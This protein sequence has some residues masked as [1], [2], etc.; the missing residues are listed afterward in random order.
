MPYVV[1]AVETSVAW[2]TADAAV[3]FEG[4][5][6]TVRPG[7]DTLY[8]TV[9]LKYEPDTKEARAEA[10]AFMRR[11]LSSLS[12]AERFGIQVVMESGGGFPI[13]LGR[14]DVHG[15]QV[16]GKWSADY[17][18]EP[19]TSEAR[20]ALAFYRE[21]LILE[22]V[23][24]P[25]SFLGFFKILNIGLPN[26]KG[27]IDW[28]NVAI[29]NIKDHRAVERIAEL[30]V[31]EPNLGEYLY[32]SGRC[33]VAHAF[34]DPVVNPDDSTDTLRLV[35]DL[36]VARALAEYFIETNLGVKSYS[37][38]LSEHRYELAGFAAILGDGLVARLKSGEALAA[39]ECP[40]FPPLNIRIDE[41]DD[42]TLSN[43]VVTKIG[44]APG[45][46]ILFCASSDAR[47]RLTLAL[48]FANER[49]IFDPERDVRVGDDGSARA[50]EYALVLLRFFRC[51]VLN[52]RT[53]V[54]RADT[55]ERLGR[56]DAYIG[57]N[58]ELKAVVEDVDR[59]IARLTADHAS[60]LQMMQST[61]IER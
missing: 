55:G 12:W 56:T 1:F 10:V 45:T 38:V 17:L 49:L 34:A 7:S 23:S 37:N 25:Y 24:A 50:V 20:L 40:A 44:S 47:L 36:P 13:Q 27:Q 42:T 22:H 61:E 58:I 43:L 53:E 28:T 3:L 2:T 35:R 18:P 39:T 29:P 6:L 8:P 59:S 9:V 15:V 21:A 51:M 16:F 52:G 14:S 30:Q 60:R 48:D 4:R 54:L 57:L 11:F 46:L 33:A 5:T 32:A 31:S 41:S 26:G 19:T